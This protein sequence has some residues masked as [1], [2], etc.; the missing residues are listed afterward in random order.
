MKTIERSRKTADR[1]LTRVS[2]E[3]SV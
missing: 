3:K 2:K 1:R